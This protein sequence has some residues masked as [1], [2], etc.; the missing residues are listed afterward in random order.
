MEKPRKLIF[1]DID[2]TLINTNGVG[3][4]AMLSALE[5]TFGKR[6]ER[7]NVS[8]AGRTDRAI[9][10]DLIIAN[11]VFV[12]DLEEAFHD[13]FSI[14]PEHLTLAAKIAKPL[15]LPGIQDLL[16]ALRKLPSIGMG[17]VTGNIMTGAHTKL[18]LANIQPGQF[19]FGAFGS[20]FS[21]RNDLPPLALSRAAHYFGVS[22]Q[23][24]EA[25]I[26]GDTPADI[27]CAKMNG[28]PALAVGT[29]WHSMETLA[30]NNPEYLLPDLSDLKKVLSLIN[31]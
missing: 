23:P 18:R 1:F 5:A 6:F 21:D 31:D 10:Q 24:T 9:I 16:A 4:R 15:V 17:L 19:R 12:P 30:E 8:F 3:G 20:D 25:L 13:I 22:F 7:K 14:F 28:I 11:N 27:E 29:G 2:G 26:I